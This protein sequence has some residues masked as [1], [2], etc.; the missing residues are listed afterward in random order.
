MGAAA[1]ST[2]RSPLRLPRVDGLHRE[3]LNSAGRRLDFATFSTKHLEFVVA[4]SEIPIR[5]G[6][7][8]DRLAVRHAAFCSRRADHP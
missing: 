7:S 2:L 6:H 8:P 4:E 3:R 1:G 5:V